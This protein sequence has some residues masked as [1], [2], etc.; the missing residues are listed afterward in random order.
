MKSVS[1]QGSILPAAHISAC[2][3]PIVLP[4]GEVSLQHEDPA[5]RTCNGH[6]PPN[7]FISFLCTDLDHAFVN[8][9]HN[10]S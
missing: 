1:F 4:S 6:Y 10:N 3:L 5:S 2:M 8:M 7:E 9:K